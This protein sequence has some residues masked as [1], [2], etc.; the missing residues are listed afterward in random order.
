M[1]I[2]IILSRTPT[3]VF[4]LPYISVLAVEETPEVSLQEHKSQDIALG[5][6]RKQNPDWRG[7]RTVLSLCNFNFSNSQLLKLKKKER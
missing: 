6:S 2:S 5:H 1:N 3:S 7:P 4:V